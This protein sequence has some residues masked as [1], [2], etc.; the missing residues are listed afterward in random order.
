MDQAYEYSDAQG[1]LLR[2]GRSI[3]IHCNEDVKIKP[4]HF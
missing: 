3:L 2:L 4:L 1:H